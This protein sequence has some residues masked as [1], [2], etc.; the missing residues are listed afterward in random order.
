MGHSIPHTTDF[1][2]SEKSIS[3]ATK[4]TP[5]IKRITSRDLF[6]QMR[7]LEIDHGGRIYKLRLTQLNKLILTA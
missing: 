4:V 5:A 3:G 2:E 7:E 6:K 1:S